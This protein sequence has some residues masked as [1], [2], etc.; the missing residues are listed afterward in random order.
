MLARAM[1]ALQVAQR[2]GQKARQ[3]RMASNAAW[4]LTAASGA[5][6]L[7]G[8]EEA[9]QIGGALVWAFAAVAWALRA[10]GRRPLARGAAAWHAAQSV[11]ATPEFEEEA[12][13]LAVMRGDPTWLDMHRTAV[14][15]M[16]GQR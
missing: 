11:L 4:V 2:E 1:P 12:R 16:T 9:L 5:A 15:Y 8:S 3:W 6:A 10:I 13:S 7:F 14:A